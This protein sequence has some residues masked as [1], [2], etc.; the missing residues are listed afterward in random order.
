MA[1]YA[2]AIATTATETA[3]IAFSDMRTYVL[4]YCDS[5]ESGQKTV[6]NAKTWIQESREASKIA[7]REANRARQ[8]CQLAR[9]SSTDMER[10]GYVRGAGT[11]SNDALN[12][13]KNARS[14]LFL[15]RDELESNTCYRDPVDDGGIITIQRVCQEADL[16]EFGAD[17]A[18]IAVIK[19]SG[20]YADLKERAMECSDLLPA[21]ELV[22]MA[23]AAL[24]RARAGQTRAR[25]LAQQARIQCQNAAKASSRTE[26]SQQMQQARELR[27]S[28]MEARE[29]ASSGYM[30]L[31]EA[32]LES[33]ICYM[34][35]S[36]STDTSVE[37]V[38]KRAD[39][40]TFGADIAATVVKNAN[41]AFSDLRERALGC[42]NLASG[43][44]L[45][46]RAK[47]L[48]AQCKASQK[49]ALIAARTAS[50]QCQ[51]AENTASDVELRQYLMNA[52]TAAT[53]SINAAG[54]AKRLLLLRNDGTNIC[55]QPVQADSNA[56]N[57]ESVCAKADAASF[58]ADLAAAAVKRVNASFNTL[59]ERAMECNDLN[60][61]Q[62]LVM[63]AKQALTVTKRSRKLAFNGARKAKRECQQAKD[64]NSSG[65][66]ELRVSNAKKFAND[67]MTAAERAR[68]SYLRMQDDMSTSICG[69]EVGSDNGAQEKT[70]PPNYTGGTQQRETSLRT[71]LVRLA[72][73][74]Y[75]KIPPEIL[76]AYSSSP[77]PDGCKLEGFKINIRIDAFQ[78]IGES[79]YWIGDEEDCKSLS[80]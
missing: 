28:V 71:W 61:G 56:I 22:M 7:Q 44:V 46:T 73:M 9:Q 32:I 29:T 24:I 4:E 53:S 26:I 58:G 43:H 49:L 12:A 19:A 64:P 63:R 62:E 10:I 38:C 14:R 15:I 54:S 78:K 52:G 3:A 33:S 48:L 39:E 18:A 16:A 76:K 36:P 20:L 75:D 68:R 21:R 77:T 23:K 51:N 67:A 13:A 79:E 40:A 1:N 65:E 11:A 25:T 59:K 57:V 72:S 30:K 47:S 41:S 34:K 45:V 17:M 35:Q 55:S 8:Q 69:E 6:M 5:F 74:L 70:K 2:A 27:D 50:T 42:G 80:L 37:A 31:K 66:L 60:L